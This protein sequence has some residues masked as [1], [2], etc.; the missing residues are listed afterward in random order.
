MPQEAD[1][2][3]SPQAAP[4]TSEPR[5]GVETP[6][7]VKVNGSDSATASTPGSVEKDKGERDREKAEK[8]KAKKKERKELR[9]RTER[10][11]TRD[12]GAEGG[13]GENKHDVTAT[14]T[15]PKPEIDTSGSPAP[16][17][18]GG[19]LS[20]RTDSTGIRT[21]TS[22]KP[23]RHPWTLFVRLPGPTNETDLRDFF[24]E[25]KDGVRIFL[26]HVYMRRRKTDS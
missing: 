12:P 11:A 20:P 13:S 14:T 6:P 8:F 24:G 21:P 16:G 2:L 7:V 10:D 1:A 23:R 5:S 3:S 15:P 22:R 9:D 26:N 19:P 25:A 17:S 18:D 4:S